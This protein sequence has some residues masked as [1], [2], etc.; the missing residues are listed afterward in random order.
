VRHKGRSIEFS[1]VDYQ[2]AATVIDSA[3]LAVALRLGV[4]R[5]KGFGCGL[6]LI[7]R[8]D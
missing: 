7:K 8:V 1:A 2:G 4:G 5:A 3:K 6:L